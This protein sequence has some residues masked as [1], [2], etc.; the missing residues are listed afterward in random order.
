MLEKVRYTPAVKVVVRF[1]DRVPEVPDAVIEDL[2]QRL[3]ELG[4]TVL[5]D[6]P[7]EGEEVEIAIVAFVGMKALVTHVLPG[8]Q[9][10]RVLLEIMGRS[11]PAELNLDFVLFNRKNAAMIALNQLESGSAGR[12]MLQKSALPPERLPHASRSMASLGAA[13]HV[14]S[15]T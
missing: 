1:G 5:T 8:K 14:Q 11:V 6:S 13:V 15:P 9:R 3:A 10:A 12:P 2:R 4:S 7:L